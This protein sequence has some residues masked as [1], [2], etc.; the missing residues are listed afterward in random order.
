MRRASATLAAFA[1]LLLSVHANAQQSSNPV[2]VPVVVRDAQGNSI[3]DLTKDDFHLFDKSKPLEI[4]SFSLEKRTATNSAIIFVIDDL[5]SSAPDLSALQSAAAKI[6]DATVREGDSAS[7]LSILG[8][9]DSGV[10]T[11]RQRLADTFA[12]LRALDSPYRLGATACPF[13]DYCHADRIENQHDERAFDIAVD[14][15]THCA[16]LDP[17]AQRLIAERQT[18]E[19]AKHAVDLGGQDVSFTYTYLREVV[20]KMAS[21]PGRRTLIFVSPGFY[22]ESPEA[23][24]LQSQL[25]EAAARANVTISTLDVRALERAEPAKLDPDSSSNNAGSRIPAPVHSNVESISDTDSV[26]SALADATGGTFLRNNGDAANSFR[27]LITAPEFVY[28]L[29]FSF[30]GSQRDDRYHPLRVTVDRTGVTIQNRR[31]YFAAASASLRA[32]MNEPLSPTATDQPPVKSSAIQPDAAP[33]AQAQSDSDDEFAPRVAPATSPTLNDETPPIKLP[34]PKGL[35]WDPPNV[36]A[37]LH[38]SSVA[39]PCKLDAVLAKAS[40]RATELIENLQNFTAREDI[41]YRTFG[42]SGLSDFVGGSA[43]FDYTATLATQNGALSV[44]ESR[45]PA[46]PGKKLPQESQD[47]GLP[48]MALIFLPEVQSDYDMKC[49]GAAIRNGR[50]AWIISFRQRQDRPDQTAAFATSDGSV[51][52]PMRGRTWIDQ[53]TG[54]VIHMDLALMHEI[55]A[56]NIREWFLAIDYAPVRFRSK[57]VVVWLP[58]SAYTYAALFDIH[59]TVASHT[60][61]NFFLFSVQTTQEVGPAPK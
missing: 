41:E 27:H 31:G 57:N 34:K 42:A 28:L 22:S 17:I 13:L 37:K 60:F 16:H 39:P 18:H 25:I 30:D 19:S 51:P 2:L 23:L 33:R 55:P 6:L 15:A 21:L 45:Q 8:A 38:S 59:R 12:Q 49:E 35:L 32:L 44:Q 36:D 61:S 53:N 3:A 50:V 43:S 40:D 46:Q 52:A 24:A 5:H 10:T 1:A 26:L 14:E 7:V 4:K 47:I 48:E 20:R 29:E 54:V 56:V 58:Q 11:D 9:D